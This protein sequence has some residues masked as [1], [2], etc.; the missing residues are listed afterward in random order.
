MITVLA[1]KGHNL[2]LF[3]CFSDV[4]ET[5]ILSLM[6]LSC[7]F[8]SSKCE[9]E[10][11]GKLKRACHMQDFGLF[12]FY[13]CY[14]HHPTKEIYTDRNV[15]K[16]CVLLSIWNIS[17]PLLPQ[18]KTPLLASTNTLTSEELGVTGSQW[19]CLRMAF[20]EIKQSDHFVWLSTSSNVMGVDRT[21]SAQGHYNITSALLTFQ[22]PTHSLCPWP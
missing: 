22:F 11:G 5:F 8:D 20:R 21:S 2:W 14:P 18:S 4:M 12:Q 17:C 16:C 19:P 9:T 13:C 15:D 1:T 10:E 7:V 3:R 6:W